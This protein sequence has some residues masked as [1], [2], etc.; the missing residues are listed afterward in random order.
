MELI[1]NFKAE[2]QKIFSVF[3]VSGISVLQFIDGKR[4]LLFTGEESD[5]SR[6]KVVY[7]LE[8]F[9][10]KM[11]IK[12]IQWRALNEISGY[13]LKNDVLFVNNS[14]FQFYNI[15]GLFLDQKFPIKE[16]VTSVKTDLA[17]MVA[18]KLLPLQRIKGNFASDLLVVDSSVPW[19][20]TNLISSKCEQLDMNCYLV[21]SQGAFVLSLE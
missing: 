2:K 6:E 16:N 11:R 9:W 15:K 1:R 17:I 3:N 8:G 12:E 14:Y 21:G 10:H 7:A 5:E 20:F 4:A 13:R 19:Y 18:S